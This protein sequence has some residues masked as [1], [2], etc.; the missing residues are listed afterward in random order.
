MVSTGSD[1]APAGSAA[2][3]PA[4]RLGGPEGNRRLIAATGALLL[5]LLAAQGVTI[6]FLDR[7]LTWHFFIGMLLVG[8]VVLKLGSTGY[9]I[10]RYY[11]G[12]PAYRRQGPPH[13][14]LRLLGPVVVA[15]TL[16]VLATGGALALLGRDTGAVPVL[17]LHKAAFVCWA[18]A[19]TV[20]VL[21]HVW[22]LPGLI[23]ADL[24][25]RAARH[26]RPR[27]RGAAIRWSLLLTAL[28]AGLALALAGAPT[29]GRWHA[30]THHATRHHDHRAAAAR[31]ALDRIPGARLT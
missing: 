19:T 6:L 16:A 8:P 27:V 22:R 3:I 23:G 24:R 9:R 28:G 11:T 5:L 15:T 14:L 18:A 29:A 12:S 20:H 25:L 4:G 7:L 26:G 13:P 1:A 10:V 21:A 30:S 31:P 17:F 2:P